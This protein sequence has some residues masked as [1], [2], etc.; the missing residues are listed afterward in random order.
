M[1]VDLVPAE[2]LGC[3][4]DPHGW[5]ID[6]EGVVYERAGTHRRNHPD[7]FARTPI[8]CMRLANE[9]HGELNAKNARRRTLY[10]RRHN[11]TVQSELD[12]CTAIMEE[13]TEDDG[14]GELVA[15]T[16]G[17]RLR[18]DRF[19]VATLEASAIR[20]VGESPLLIKKISHNGC[21]KLV[22]SKCASLAG[23]N[24][25]QTDAV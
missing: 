20:H 25:N 5:A 17:F 2:A 14:Q 8:E 15:V 3:A 6:K 9:A 12:A 19:A 7:I 21:V 16:D 22:F 11:R 24:V 13:R 23:K 4:T 10:S 18:I 1:L